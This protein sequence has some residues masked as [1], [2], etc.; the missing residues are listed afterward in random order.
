MSRKLSTQFEDN[1][2]VILRAA[3]ELFCR[4]G[5]H[6]A[7]ISDIAKTVKLSKGT[8]SYYYPSKDHLIYEV[9]DFHLS[10]VTDSLLKWMGAVSPGMPTK[11]VLE[12]FFAHM[13]STEEKCRLHICLLSEAILGNEATRRL[14]ADSLSKWRAMAEAGLLKSG[15]VH[16]G[17]VT[18][19]LFVALDSVILRRAMGDADLKIGGICAHIADHV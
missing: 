16:Y 8:V 1:R 14:L 12:S 9:T 4:Q 17:P 2:L 18:D 13:F 3:S 19:A 7:S 10:K 5:I 11:E 15:S 6:G